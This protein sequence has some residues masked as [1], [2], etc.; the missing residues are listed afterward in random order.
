MIQKAHIGIGIKG[1]EGSQAAQS[2]DYVIGQFRFLKKLLL[3]H[4]RWSY[5][6]LSLMILYFFYKNVAVAM[7]SFWFSIDTR[8]SG[9]VFIF[10][11]LLDNKKILQGFNFT[12]RQYT[13][14]SQA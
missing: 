3:V 9:Q 2:S 4:G 8:F 12:K 6:R 13:I 1:K 10:L 5:Y 7:V 14:L 11:V